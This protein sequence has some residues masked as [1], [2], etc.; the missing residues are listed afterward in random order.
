MSHD[1]SKFDLNAQ[2]PPEKND[3][4]YNLERLNGRS[5]STGCQWMRRRSCLFGVER[6]SY[7]LALIWTGGARPTSTHRTLDTNPNHASAEDTFA[8]KQ[9]EL[10]LEDLNV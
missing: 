2:E 6:S 7:L 3:V 4:Y 8:E 9:R 5:S 1:W 10:I